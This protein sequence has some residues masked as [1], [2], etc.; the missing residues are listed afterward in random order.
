MKKW[1]NIVKAGGSLLLFL[2]LWEGSVH[3][4]RIEKWILPAPTD[5]LTALIQH[6]PLIM[7][8]SGQTLVE[9]LIGLAAATLLGIA[10]ATLMDRFLLLRD[11]IYPLLVITQTVPTVALAPLF[12]LWFGFGMLPKVLVVII[13]TFFP[14]AVSLFE[15]YRQVDE[16]QVR[17]LSSMGAT[18]SQ[19]F[20]YLKI[21]ASLPSFFAGL[22]IAGTYGVMAAVV[23]EWLGANRGLGILLIRSSKSYLTDQLFATILVIILLSLFLYWIIEWLAALIMPWRRF[24]EERH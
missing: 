10:I 12:M 15:G 8:H 5:V 13:S 23:G 3:L 22:R 16:E 11:A 24:S 14:V 9:T 20:R 1:L 18:R 6:F 7:M 4:F 2:L 21:P 17:L 19:I